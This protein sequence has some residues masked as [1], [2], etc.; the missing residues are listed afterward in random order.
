MGTFALSNR[1]KPN[2]CLEVGYIVSKLKR[3]TLNA[4][5]FAFGDPPATNMAG[6]GHL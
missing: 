5:Y 2:R 4:S 3:L 6:T 1:T